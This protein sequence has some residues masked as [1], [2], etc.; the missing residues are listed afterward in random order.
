MPIHNHYKSSPQIQLHNITFKSNVLEYSRTQNTHLL[1]K[2]PFSI[3]IKHLHILTISLLNCLLNVI[4]VQYPMLHLINTVLIISD[5]TKKYANQ[6]HLCVRKRRHNFKRYGDNVLFH[7][8]KQALL[9]LMLSTMTNN[10]PIYASRL[11]PTPTWQFIIFPYLRL[12]F[13][14]ES[15]S[16]VI[17]IIT[18][19]PHVAQS[20]LTFISHTHAIP[21]YH[22]LA[23]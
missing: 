3:N 5:N 7:A 6:W 9:P 12:I 8:S 2:I 13:F 18:S 4:I 21:S 19:N 23:P 17:K 14:E 22:T 16:T 1:N 15:L 20:H 11:I 10:V